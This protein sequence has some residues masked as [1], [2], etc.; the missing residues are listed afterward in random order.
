MSYFRAKA[1][2]A[3]AGDDVTSTINET[4]RKMG[5]MFSKTFSKSF[6]LISIIASF[7]KVKKI[8]CSSL[9]RMKLPFIAVKLPLSG[10]QSL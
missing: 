10:S 1:G 6:D 4:R 5:K 8:F 9:R 2:M 3:F 7:H